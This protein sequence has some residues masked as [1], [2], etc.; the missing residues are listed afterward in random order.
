MLLCAIPMFFYKISGKE[1]ERIVTELA[2]KRAR[3]GVV[4]E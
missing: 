3:E 1:K 4:V 2:E